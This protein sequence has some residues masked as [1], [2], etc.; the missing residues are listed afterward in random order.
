V[1]VRC[2]FF[3]R[4]LTRGSTGFN[5]C[6]LEALA[7]VCP[8]AFLSGVHTALIVTIIYYVETLKV[9]V[10]SLDL[11]RVELSDLSSSTATAVAGVGGGYAASAQAALHGGGVLYGALVCNQGLQLLLVVIRFAQCC[12]WG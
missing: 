2:A 9:A 8:V 11:R 4:N 12:G 7:C 5:A 10:L 3:D 1:Y 6:S